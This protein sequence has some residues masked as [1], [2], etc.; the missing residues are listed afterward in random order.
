[1]PPAIVA[2]DPDVLFRRFLHP[3]HRGSRSCLKYVKDTRLLC[4]NVN[5]WP[6]IWTTSQPLAPIAQMSR[7]RRRYVRSCCRTFT[8]A[9][10]N[11]PRL[12]AVPKICS[13]CLC[14]VELHCMGALAISTACLHAA[15]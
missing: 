3:V 4:R 10:A 2:R 12:L 7:F 15:P 8:S 13:K 6:G 5:R 11:S 1:R 14:E 9:F